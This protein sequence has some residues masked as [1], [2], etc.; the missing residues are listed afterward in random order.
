MRARQYNKQIEVWQTTH[1]S[2]GFGG[3][4]VTSAL[5][6]KSW[7]KITTPNNNHGIYRT[8][9]VGVTDT[10]NTLVVTL[11]KRNDITY[12]SLNQYFLYR[13][14]KYVISSEPINV[15]FED[16]DIQIVITKENA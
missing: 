9:N 13:G 5:L 4:G 15:G 14:V 10:S 12:N 6:T 8:T 16:R 11:R 2:D 3:N 1:V 7:C